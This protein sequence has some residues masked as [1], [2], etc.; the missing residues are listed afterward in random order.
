MSAR[1]RSV[2]ARALHAEGYAWQANG[3]VRPRWSAFGCGWVFS[4]AALSP[5]S[6]AYLLAL[7]LRAWRRASVLD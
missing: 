1:V 6:R 5:P 7:A 4:N 3:C 2:A